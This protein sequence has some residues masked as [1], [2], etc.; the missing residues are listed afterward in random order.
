MIIEHRLYTLKSGC[1]EAFWQAQTTR[2]FD[3]VRPILDRLFGYF[4]AASSPRDQITH[5]YC[6]SSF[7]DW[8]ARLHGLYADASL[9]TYFHAVRQLMTA[10]EN[11]FLVRAPLALL[12]P[13]V[14]DG[15]WNLSASKIPALGEQAGD[16]VE[17]TTTQLLPGAMPVFWQA[18]ERCLASGDPLITRR[19]IGCFATLVGP[20]H[21]VI[22]Y[23][24]FTG[25][26]AR[27]THADDLGA[28]AVWQ[29]FLGAIRP[30]IVTE[31]RKLLR[32]SPLLE[33]SPL[34]GRRVVRVGAGE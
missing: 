4:E 6:F 9:T 18:Y 11:K 23:R 2:G 10:Q 7:D 16:L 21:Q 29:E 15:E 31:V 5:L 12:N 30:L 33:L 14:P 13:V 34:F 19:L 32:P 3:H 17:E 20:L 22:H 26:I 24:N 8:K 27:E 28:N 1:T 25:N